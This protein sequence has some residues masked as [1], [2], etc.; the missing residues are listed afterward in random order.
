MRQLRRGVEGDPNQTSHEPPQNLD[1]P[2]VTSRLS[3]VLQQIGLHLWIMSL[4]VQGRSPPGSNADGYPSVHLPKGIAPLQQWLDFNPTMPVEMPLTNCVVE[5]MSECQSFFWGFPLTVLR[6]LFALVIGC[7]F[8]YGVAS[9]AMEWLGDNSWFT[10]LRNSL[11]DKFCKGFTSH[12][13]VSYAVA[14]VLQIFATTLFSGVFFWNTDQGFMPFTWIFW[15]LEAALGT[16]SSN[17]VEVFDELSSHNFTA[18]DK[19]KVENGTLNTIGTTFQFTLVATAIV[20]NVYA[21]R[22]VRKHILALDPDV[23]F[24]E[25]PVLHPKE[26]F[27]PNIEDLREMGKQTILYL[28]Y[29]PALVFWR[30]FWASYVGSSIFVTLLWLVCFVC[31]GGKGQVEQRTFVWMVI[32]HVIFALSI[33]CMHFYLRLYAEKCLLRWE[34][35]ETGRTGQRP[36][37][38][39]GHILRIRCLCLFSWCQVLSCA[40]AATL[41]PFVA[42]YDYLK[43]ILTALLF[44]MV[45]H[46]PQLA[47]MGEFCDYTYCC[48]C[49]CLYMEK[50]AH[51]QTHVTEAVEFAGEEDGDTELILQEPGFRVGPWICGFFSILFLVPYL[52]WVFLNLMSRVLGLGCDIMEN[53][54]VPGILSFG[55]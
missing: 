9:L 54:G 1:G 39:A 26:Y 22:H 37:S 48:Y 32:R 10:C 25:D 29:L 13:M 15:N 28:S 33:L 2:N 6:N 36:T 38:R 40:V 50:V 20:G 34:D 49:A 12:I 19:W 42:V 7:F 43:C 45:P 3:P 53:D 52:V 11:G 21:Y 23:F 30:L 47:Q 18:F 46:K 14:A 44:A 17:H 16:N 8:L 4:A 55:C 35:P 51:H 24:S 41:G 31:G 5:Q 27:G